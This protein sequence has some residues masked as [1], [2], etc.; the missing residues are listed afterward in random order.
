MRRVG[1]TFVTLWLIFLFPSLLVWGFMVRWGEASTARFESIWRWCAD[2]LAFPLVLSP[3]TD[4]SWISLREGTSLT[5]TSG[6][7]VLTSVWALMLALPLAL[8]GGWW[9]WITHRLS[10]SSPTPAVPSPMSYPGSYSSTLSLPPTTAPPPGGGPS[11]AIH[12]ITLPIALVWTGLR[13]L[14]SQRRINHPIFDW[15]RPIIRASLLVFVLTIVVFWIF[16]ISVEHGEQRDAAHSLI[17]SVWR[18]YLDFLRVPSFFDARYT[19]AVWGVLDHAGTSSAADW[20]QTTLLWFFDP[21][22][23]TLGLLL[24][25]RHAIGAFIA[26]FVLRVLGSIF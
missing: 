26:A 19:M 24:A 11:G 25:L 2:R 12:L 6:F 16:W 13:T 17:H 15:W 8:I 23:R 4:W 18:G 3:I 9:V 21:D 22:L 1:S 10:R 7:L 14:F 5:A 20:D